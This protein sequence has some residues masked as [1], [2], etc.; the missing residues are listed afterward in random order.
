MGFSIDRL[1][2]DAGF[3]EDEIVLKGLGFDKSIEVFFTSTDGH[4]KGIITFRKE[5]SPTYCCTQ[6]SYYG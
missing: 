5:D 1:Y 4:K 2:P 6:R 3:H